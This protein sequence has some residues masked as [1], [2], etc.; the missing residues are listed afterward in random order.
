MKYYSTSVFYLDL[1]TGGYG[2]RQDDSCDAT[3]EKEWT[4]R[5]VT[6]RLNGHP[7]ESDVDAVLDQFENT[8]QEIFTS[9]WSGNNCAGHVPKNE[10]FETIVASLNDLCEDDEN[11]Y[12]I[13]YAQGWVRDHEITAET[14]D[15]ELDQIIEGIEKSLVN[16]RVVLD[17]NVK[18]AVYAQ[19]NWLR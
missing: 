3:P 2:V 18:E 15:K 11:C 13:Q 5:T 9:T 4:G 14:T 17:E 10:K 1:E 12:S 6:S 7:L 8:I 16:E 19:R